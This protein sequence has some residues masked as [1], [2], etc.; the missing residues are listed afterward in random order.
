MVIQNRNRDVFLDTSGW[1]SLL[2]KDERS[3]ARAHKLWNDI[4]AGRGRVFLSD[5][6]V[7]ETGNSVARSKAR[8]IF[9]AAVLRL[10]NH[11]R[12]VF[13][14]VTDDL[15]DAALDLY[16][17]RNDKAWGLVDCCSFE[18]MWQNDIT[19]AFSLDHHFAQAGFDCLLLEK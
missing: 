19:A 9:S 1:V 5:W 11:P 4:L 10:L 3:H 18:V 16:S 17:E 8:T 15:R 14:K 6:I 13:V 7:A 2:N 12:I